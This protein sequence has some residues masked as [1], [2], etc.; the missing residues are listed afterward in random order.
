VRRFHVIELTGGD[1]TKELN[2]KIDAAVPA[3]SDVH[4]IQAISVQSPS[5][6]SGSVP[7]LFVFLRE[8]DKTEGKGRKP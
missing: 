6:E 5:W 7:R 1:F 3:G 2:A 4:F 8:Y